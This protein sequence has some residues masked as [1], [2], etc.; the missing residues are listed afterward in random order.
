M[1]VSDADRVLVGHSV[2]SE[3][4]ETVAVVHGDCVACEK[5]AV[6][7]RHTVGLDDRVEAPEIDGAAEDVSNEVRV[8]LEVAQPVG[9]GEELLKAEGDPD[10][11][12]SAVALAVTVAHGERLGDGDALEA[13]VGDVD[14]VT[15]PEA[16]RVGERDTELV[17]LA[18]EDRLIDGD[19][20]GERLAD[21]D[22]EAVGHGESDAVAHAE[23]DVEREVHDEGVAEL[24]LLAE[25]IEDSEPEF[26]S[27]VDGE[28][29]PLSDKTD[30]VAAA[31]LHGLALL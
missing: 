31:V 11:D 29:V 6:A 5:V 24:S 16:L 18:A 28:F 21:G 15:L 22:L 25:N 7:D 1:G 2:A 27:R 14:W 20:D 17:T 30:R 10:R 9:L 8:T 23:P 4:R 13:L 12:C 3:D 26:E 19:G